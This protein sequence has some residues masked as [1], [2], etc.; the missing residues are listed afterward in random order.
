[1]KRIA[2]LTI[3]WGLVLL[4]LAPMA[5]ASYQVASASPA[6]GP[7]GTAATV[8]ISGFL[9]GVPVEVHEGSKGGTLLG[10]AIANVSGIAGVPITIPSSAPPGPYVLYVCGSCASEFHD[11]ATTTFDVVPP[12]TTTTT[13]T[14]SEAPPPP[15]TTSPPTT[16]PPPPG[17]PCVI[18][19]DAIVIDFDHYDLALGLTG[20][21]MGPLERAVVLDDGHDLYFHQWS[22]YL[23]PV[24]PPTS[25]DPS[26]LM[27]PRINAI[28]RVADNPAVDLWTTSP[29]NVMRLFDDTNWTYTP[30]LTPI[31]SLIG[32]NVGF[33]HFGEG[34]ETPDEVVVELRVTA[35]PMT[36]PD[37]SIR[38]QGAWASASIT[39]GPGPQ[40]V[41]HCLQARNTLG[42]V[43]PYTVYMI[44]ILPRTAAGDPIHIPLDIDDL[45]FARIEP[46]TPP[47]RYDVDPDTVP[48][49]PTITVPPEPIPE[50]TIPAP[51]PETPDPS[52][53]WPLR[54][55]FGFA[56]LIL[57]AGSLFAF[58][59]D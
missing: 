37:G 59:R 26:L 57:G 28:G 54:L 6:S 34:F 38:D 46:P 39:L 12:P 9:P 22:E 43:D 56:G 45:F 48:A 10:S 14:T 35:M 41:T 20:E 50:V 7:P 13:T 23:L 31:P 27:T 55:A 52:S 36:M 4:A 1:M 17:E 21:L 8:I 53:D 44:D 24:Y 32:F 49:A 33:G 3:A 47:F 42:S 58:R 30:W 19:D 29:P 51:V 15:D 11:E 40:P 5:S 2:G 25:D 16:E 18:P